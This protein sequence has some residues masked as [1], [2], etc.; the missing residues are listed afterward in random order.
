MGLLSLKE[1][2]VVCKGVADYSRSN[3]RIG[4][5]CYDCMKKL[6]KQGVNVINIKKYEISQLQQM[7]KVGEYTQSEEQ[8]NQEEMGVSY[9]LLEKMIVKNPSI[10]LKK[11]EVCF[12]EKKA[13]AFHQK[14]VVTGTMR[15]S[16]GASVRVAKGLSFRIGGGETQNIRENVGEHYDGI[17]YVTNMRILLLAS[18]YGF[19]ISIPKITSIVQRKDGLQFYVGDKCHNVL[20]KDV[21][22]IIKLFNTM[23]QAFDEQP[24]S[25][26]KSKTDV[27]KEIREYKQ[28]LDEGILT[29][30]EFEEKKKQ[31]L[32]L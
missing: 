3:T 17:L 12:Y 11:G 14:N 13:I 16:T 27:V 2:C 4:P 10:S 19:E 26:E 8:N 25:N 30:E 28:L 23:N 29:L 6:T 5:V 15:S 1:T 21:K 22:S 32:K 24:K 31:L 7:C 9:S 18:K 20:T